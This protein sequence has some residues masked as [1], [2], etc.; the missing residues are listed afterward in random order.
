MTIYHNYEYDQMGS[1]LSIPKLLKSGLRVY[2]FSGD[3]DDVVP[4]TDT[5]KNI[6]KMGLKQYGPTKPMTL[7]AQHI[8]FKKEYKYG[9]E[10]KEVLRFYLIKGAGHEVPMYQRERSYHVFEEFLLGQ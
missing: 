6:Y 5:Y 8:G 4:F 7:K 2:L 3:W 10:D 1:Y 9:K